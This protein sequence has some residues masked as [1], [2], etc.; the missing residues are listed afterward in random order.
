[1]GERAPF[2]LTIARVD[3]LLFSGDAVGVV[4]PGVEG[5]MTVLAHHASLISPL[6]AGIITVMKADGGRETF[7]IEEGTLE[8]SGNQT[9]ILL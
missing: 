6:R 5:E 9:T 4:V 2:T 1:M 3:G 8:V 7:A